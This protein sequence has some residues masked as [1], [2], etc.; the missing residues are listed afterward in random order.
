MTMR[1]F[2]FEVRKYIREYKQPLKC[3]EQTEEKFNKLF[4]SSN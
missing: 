1:I 4:K 2:V 3:S